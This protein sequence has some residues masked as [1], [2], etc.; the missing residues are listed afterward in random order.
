[1]KNQKSELT[2]ATCGQLLSFIKP[3]WP[4]VVL[5]VVAISVSA[6]IDVLGGYFI[7]NITDNALNGQSQEILRTIYLII[8]AVFIGI[9]AKYGV[10]YTSG[11]FSL[12]ALR[13]V[14]KNTTGSVVRMSFSDIE[15][16]HSGD[17]VSRLTNDAAVIQDFFQ[18]S[19]A[20]FL[21][22]PIAFLATFGYMATLNLKLL[23]VAVA[24]IPFTFFVTNLL[25]RPV[26][27]WVKKRQEGFGRINAVVQD[28]IGGI[29][30]QK[31]FNLDRVLYDKFKVAVHQV[32]DNEL[33]RQKR[34]SI[35]LTLFIT[36]RQ[37]PVLVTAAYGGYLA[38]NGQMTPGSLFAFLYLLH[39][40]FGII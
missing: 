30:M 38:I 9:I 22:Q 21:Y 2:W 12:Y 34:L 31:A 17:M 20:N 3:H 6:I 15:A 4:W 18:N 1:M 23:L 40:T 24:I 36:I 25:S 8:V 35:M 5:S 26:G 33:K 11:R 28:T 27:D 10:K 29:N 32:R 19:F 13:D 37:V 14:R 39:L 16:N 7:K